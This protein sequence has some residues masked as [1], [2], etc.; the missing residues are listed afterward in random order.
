M[1]VHIKTAQNYIV[2]NI[3]EKILPQQKT[4]PPINFHHRNKWSLSLRL[5]FVLASSFLK[6]KAFNSSTDYTWSRNCWRIPEKKLYYSLWQKWIK[7]TKKCDREKR[8]KWKKKSEEY[9]QLYCIFL[10]PML[11]S[12]CSHSP[13]G[14]L[15]LFHFVRIFVCVYV[16][17]SS[18][19]HTKNEMHTARNIYVIW[20]FFQPFSS[21]ENKKLALC[22]SF[23]EQTQIVRHI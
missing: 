16:G 5:N 23:P 1:F 21:S 6:L 7:F 4:N 20:K 17:I 14:I 13:A 11:P 2:I 18:E 3:H 19:M 15:R 10:P 8:S 9:L 22:A 12:A